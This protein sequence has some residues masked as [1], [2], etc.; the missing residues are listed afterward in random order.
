MLFIIL[1]NFIIQ[2]PCHDNGCYLLI[3]SYSEVAAWIPDLSTWGFWLTKW[4]WELSV[5]IYVFPLPLAVCECSVLILICL[6]LFSETQVDKACVSLN[7]AML[8]IKRA[9]YTWF[10]KF[11]C[12]YHTVSCNLRF[13]ATVRWDTYN[14]I[15]NY[16]SY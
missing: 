5:K 4:Y 12:L 8:F 9:K 6:L 1:M 3:V 13:V 7:K 16:K 15:Y 10:Y 14:G 11:C 2:R